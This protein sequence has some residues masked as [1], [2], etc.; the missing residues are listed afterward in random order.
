[1]TQW[2]IP[3]VPMHGGTSKG[4]FF[5]EDDLPRDPDRVWTVIKV[6]L[7]RRCLMDDWMRVNV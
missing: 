3:A 6:V 1:M 2:R 4:L 7:S 5:C